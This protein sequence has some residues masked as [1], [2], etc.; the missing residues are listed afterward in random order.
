MKTLMVYYTPRGEQSATKELADYFATLVK[1]E[2][3]KLDI[4][5]D[6][7]PAFSNQ[8]IGAYYK[9][10]YGKQELE[11]GEEKL[12][13]EFE[14][15]CKQF[16]SADIV[17][18]AYP[19]YNFTFPAAVKAYFDAIMLKGET[20]DLG[21]AGF[22]GLLKG[23]KAAAITTSGGAYEWSGSAGGEHSL[24]LAKELLGFMGLEAEGVAA[25]GLNMYP[26]KKGEIMGAAKGKLEEIA[27]KFYG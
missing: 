23:K 14:K 19:M 22:V 13:G 15:L 16:V 6:L 24:K 21:S 12:M 26:D 5:K 27:K 1:G 9:K 11:G 3:E 20:W 18:L 4:G 25:E 8:S 17:V 10:Y 2:V 7:P